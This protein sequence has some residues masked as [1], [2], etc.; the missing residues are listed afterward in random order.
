MDTQGHLKQNVKVTLNDDNRLRDN[1][2]QPVPSGETVV[3]FKHFLS[4][5]DDAFDTYEILDPGTTLDKLGSTE[6]EVLKVVRLMVEEPHENFELDTKTLEENQVMVLQDL[7]EMVEQCLNSDDESRYDTDVINLPQLEG[8]T[9]DNTE[10]SHTLRKIS[11]VTSERREMSIEISEIIR[12]VSKIATQNRVSEENKSQSREVQQEATAALTNALKDQ[13]AAAQDVATQQAKALSE[14]IEAQ[15]E[16]ISGSLEQQFFALS[17]P[18]NFFSMSNSKTLFWAITGPGTA[19]FVLPTL[20][21]VILSQY[22]LRKILRF[23]WF[24][25]RHG[26]IH[27]V[28][29]QPD[30]YAQMRYLKGL[31]KCKVKVLPIGTKQAA[32]VANEAEYLQAPPEIDAT[33]GPQSLTFGAGTPG[34]FRFDHKRGRLYLDFID[35]FDYMY[36]AHIKPSFP[37]STGSCYREIVWKRVQLPFEKDA[38]YF[39]GKFKTVERVSEDDKLIGEEL[40]AM[41]SNRGRIMWDKDRQGDLPSINH[42]VRSFIKTRFERLRTPI[43][44]N[45]GCA[46]LHVTAFVE[47]TRILSKAAFPPAP[48]IL[49]V[50]I[51]W[52]YRVYM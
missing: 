35:T 38:V 1:F 41:M 11:L 50:S 34:E 23:L 24:L 4:P 30:V 3:Y 33:R 44:K 8:G 45:S 15:Q 40:L 10:R 46:E 47:T 52:K 28:L 21:V 2:N 29:K 16:T 39:R 12:Q 20:W 18:G 51:V 17:A 25:F 5:T 31:Q 48:P 19:F 13:Q 22:E 27:P 26:C 14:A 37:S 42:R 43:N 6:A 9:D 36:Y 32:G 49:L 7:K